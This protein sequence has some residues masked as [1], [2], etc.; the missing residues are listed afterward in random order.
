[1][2]LPIKEHL[3]KVE[4]FKNSAEKRLDYTRLDKNEG[5]AVFTEKFMDI[6]KK[7]ITPDFLTAYPEIYSL[8]EKIAKSLKCGNDNIYV[9]AGSDAGIKAVFEVFVEK[10]DVV[11]LLEPTY[12]MFYV[13][14]GIFEAKLEKVTYDKDLS[15]SADSVIKK[16]SDFKP[17]LVCIANPNSPTGTILPP[18]DIKKIALSACENKSILLIDEAYYPFYPITALELIK[19]F[20]N[21]IITRTFSK[22]M[23]LASA[24]LGYVVGADKIIEALR[25]VRPMYETNAFAAKFAEIIMNNPEVLKKN[26]KEVK[27]AKKYV[28]SELDEMGISYFK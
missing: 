3:K 10:G 7:E 12:A 16:I 9:T 5:I 22:A 8:Q 24:R 28:E 14:A 21:V 4:R 27:M 20:S 15:L 18:D 26:L 25:K 1:M 13:Y 6:L 11:V 17:K 23:A 19:E 2:D